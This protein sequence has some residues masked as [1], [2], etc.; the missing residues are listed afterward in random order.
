MMFHQVAA[1]GNLLCLKSVKISFSFV[2]SVEKIVIGT[3][4]LVSR[5]CVCGEAFTWE[6]QPFT[7]S[8]SS[9]NL[10]PSSAILISGCSISQSLTMFQHANISCFSELPQHLTTLSCTSCRKSLESTSRC[11]IFDVIRRQN[12]AVVDG[13]DARCC[14]PGH[15]AKYGSYS[16]MDLELGQIIDVQLVQSNEVKSSYWMELKGLIRC[17][18]KVEEEGVVISDLVT[19]RHSQ[20]KAYMKKERTNFNNW[21][22]VWHVAKG[23][24]KKLE[25]SGKKKMCKQVADWAR[26]VSNQLYWCAASSDGDGE[27][28]S[29]KWLSNLNHITNVNE[30]HGERFPKFLHGELEDRD[31]IKKGSLAF[32]EMEKFVRGRLLVED[33][34][35]LFQ[36][37]QTSALEAYHN[38]VFHF[39]PKALHFFYGPI[40]ARLYIAALHFNENSSREQA[41]NKRGDPIYS[42]A[43]PK[44]RKGNGIPREV[45][46][47]QTY[48]YA[49]KLM[50]EVIRLRLEFGSNRESRKSFEAAVRNCPAP[51]ADSYKHVP[52][53]ELAERHIC[54]FNKKC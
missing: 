43:Y 32:Q 34:K 13:G 37:E 1:A 51:I 44:G 23:V 45:K 46:V 53:T 41:V 11:L 21:F 27:M 8:M 33:I 22:D 49:V 48:N 42:V 25:T 7:G 18:K 5:V 31:W 4:L 6:S 10:V 20:I 29:E 39:E 14:S 47:K 26:S 28:V 50:E 15:T 17:L 19:D 52:K 38:V 35:K 36:A 24:F 2:P 30:G 12:E 3:L 16:Q 40:K 9:G 54:R